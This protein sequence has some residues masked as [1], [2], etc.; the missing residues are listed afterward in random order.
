LTAVL[1]LDRT[2]EIFAQVKEAVLT[3]DEDTAGGSNLESHPSSGDLSASLSNTKYS[4]YE[5]QV[6]A[7]QR[8]SS[9]YCDEPEDENDFASWVATFNMDDRKDEIDEILLSNAFMQELHN[10]I[11]PVVV[12][13]ETFWTRY[14]YRLNKLQQ[15]E[16]ARVNLVKRATDG[17]E[18]ED[19]SWD[20]D[21]E[22]DT[23][24]LILPAE[25]VVEEIKATEATPSLRSIEVPPVASVEETHEEEETKS[26]GSTGSEWLVV[27][28][29]KGSGTSEPKSGPSSP[30]SETKDTEPSGAGKSEDHEVDEAELDQ[31]ADLTIDD[32]GHEPIPAQRDLDKGSTETD[33]KEQ[34]EED[35]GE[36]E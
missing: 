3:V 30:V 35:W 24:D 2:T 27:S 22:K 23:E 8:D 18:D 25:G 31:I 19:L 20:V 13:H 15:I 34:N 5:A 7:M 4:R 12:E 9:T 1:H 33:A 21:E 16:N 10:Q 32:D 14:F 17:E 28:E 29:D 36:W 11:V 6:N 26:E